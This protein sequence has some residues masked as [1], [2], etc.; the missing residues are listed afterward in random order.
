MILIYYVK[1]IFSFF[2]EIHWNQVRERTGAVRGWRHV[3]RPLLT[4]LLVWV[5]KGL[6]G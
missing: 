4:P 3:N 2:I 1:L 6:P 5:K